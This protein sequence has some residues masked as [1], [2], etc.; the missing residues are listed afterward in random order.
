[1]PDRHHLPP[2]LEVYSSTIFTSFKATVEQV[3]Q[4]EQA[5]S[6]R[7]GMQLHDHT[8]YPA[9]TYLDLFMELERLLGFQTIFAI[10]KKTPEVAL[11][12]ADITNIAEA[13]A[14]I[15]IAYHM[16]HRIGGRPA[17][18]PA[19]GK[20]LEGIGHY[21]FRLD[22]RRR[23]VMVCDNPYPSGFDFGIITGTARKFRPNAEVVYDEKQPSRRNKGESCTYIVTW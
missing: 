13:L 5:I 19:T 3:S 12:P 21:A 4:A 14:S 23:A 18:D 1:M 15:D 17:F 16:N 11:W 20:M 10:G 22:G 7:L 2:D 6:A 8:W 9:V